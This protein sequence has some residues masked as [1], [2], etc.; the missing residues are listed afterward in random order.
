MATPTPESLPLP[1]RRRELAQRRTG[2]LEITLYW[3]AADGSISVEVHQ[4]A[5]RETI[6]FPVAREHALDAFHHPLCPHDPEQG[7]AAK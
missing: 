3:D 2:G 6:A 4:P 7:T 1:L 5:T